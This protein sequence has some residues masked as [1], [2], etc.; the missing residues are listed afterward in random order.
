MRSLMQLQS[1]S[2]QGECGGRVAVRDASIELVR[3]S[4]RD[5]TSID[6][7]VRASLRSFGHGR[8]ESGMR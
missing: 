3:P 8:E 5:A 1:S 4:A 2:E 6:K 7:R